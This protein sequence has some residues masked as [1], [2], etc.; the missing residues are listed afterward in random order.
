M[1]ISVIPVPVA[2]SGTTASS[3]TCAAPNTL[4]AAAL[5]LEPAIYT[6]T[7][8]SS[9]IARIE[10]YSDVSTFITSAT[11][12]SGSV[13]VNLGTAVDRVRVW[14]NTGTDVPVIINKTAVA[15]TNNLSGTLD[16]ITST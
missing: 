14:T 15:L 1:G 9:T 16:T 3:I 12:S 8:T 7:C 2:S 4:Y 6:I 5:E 10:F 13:S 11:T